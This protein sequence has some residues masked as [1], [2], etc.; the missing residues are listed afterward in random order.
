MRHLINLVETME[1]PVLYH[2]TKPR[3]RDLILAQGLTTETS[4]SHNEFGPGIYL[5]NSID[6]AR[7]YGSLVFSVDVSKLNL[8][9]MMPDDYE[10]RD[11]FDGAWGDGTEGDYSEDELRPSGIFEADW[12]DSLRICQ[13]CQYLGTIPADALREVQTASTDV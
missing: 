8:R 12:K 5:T 6:V 3:L 1:F 13:Q 2:G 9:Q 11:Y 7:Q 4:M 10:L